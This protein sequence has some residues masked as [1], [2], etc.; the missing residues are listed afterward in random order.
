[1]KEALE[2]ADTVAGI[3]REVMLRFPV[4]VPVPPTVVASPFCM[5]EE[6][7]F[8]FRLA[9]GEPKVPLW[10]KV[11]LS[12]LRVMGSPRRLVSTKF[13]VPELTISMLLKV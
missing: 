13:K 10:V 6:L 8:K 4:P 5:N 7:E 12:R 2:L 3:L 9:T 1:M 11:E